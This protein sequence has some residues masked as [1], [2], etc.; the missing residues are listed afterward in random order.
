MLQLLFLLSSILPS[1]IYSLQ[2]QDIYGVTQSM[3][4]FQN[5]KVLLVNIATGSPKAN[6]LAE[7][8]Y[9]HQQHGDSLVIIGFP[10]NS[11]GN[12][13]KT[14]A[15]IKLFCETTYGITFIL[16]SK[17][18]VKGSDI[19]PV[20]NW[21]TS[22][23]ENGSLGDPVRGDF[24]KFLISKDGELVGFFSGS[25]KPTDPLIINAITGN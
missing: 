6:Q 1:S 3:S 5:K 24:Q 7:L 16:A 17:K 14:D 11:F 23:S 13:T 21:L 2:F 20:Y 12:E 25:T 4:Q 8:Q 9:L 19:Q 10:T 15:E 18:S 22:M